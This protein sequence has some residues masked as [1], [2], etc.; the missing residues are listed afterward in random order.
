MRKIR[1]LPEVTIIGVS[2]NSSDWANRARAFVE[3]VRSSS[4][5]GR[6]ELKIEVNPPFRLLYDLR[7]MELG[8]AGGVEQATYELISAISGLDRKN[9]HQVFAPRSACWEWDFPSRFK[10]SRHYSDEGPPLGERIRS[11]E[12]AFDLVIS[13]SSY[14]HP[15][16]SEE[17][18]VGKECRL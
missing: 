13:T 6:S 17:R 18:R 14:I 10:A 11:R 4:R 3:T 5:D 15:E 1:D 7:W 9:S 8:R 16:R 12:I 2:S